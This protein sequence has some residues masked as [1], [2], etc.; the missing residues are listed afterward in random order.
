MPSPGLGAGGLRRGLQS[1]LQ[2]ERGPEHDSGFDLPACLRAGVRAEA[3]Q[4]RQVCNVCVCVCAFAYL[5]LCVCVHVGMSVCMRFFPTVI[6]CMYKFTHMRVR[7]QTCV[8][9]IF[10]AVIHHEH[11]N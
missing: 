2:H 5:F 3:M 4:P 11:I 9:I 8:H 6:P 10:V 1:E 7:V